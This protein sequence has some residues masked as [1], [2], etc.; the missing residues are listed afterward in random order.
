MKKTS[1]ASRAERKRAPG[2]T[3][4]KSLPRKTPRVRKPVG[5][6]LEQWQ[7]ALRRE[8]G[9]E[10]KFSA[11][12]IGDEEIFS[13]FIITNPETG[14]S[15]RAAI[16]GAQPG[17]NYCSCPD[18]SVN[19]LGTCKHLE[20]LLGKLE[21]KRGGKKA[22]REGHRTPYPEVYLRYGA[23]RQVVFNPGSESSIRLW[24]LASEYFD[25]P[26][27]DSSAHGVLRS[28]AYC[29][30]DKFLKTAKRLAPDLRVYDDALAFIAQARDDES[31][32]KLLRGEFPKGEDS[33][34]FKKLLNVSLYPYQRAGA[35]FA[36][37]A[38]RCLLADDM[39]LGKTIQ[40]IA[41][42][43]MLARTCGVE[44]VLVICPTSLKHQ[45]K[46]E[47]DR[48]CSRSTQVVEGLIAARA[49]CYR[50]DSFFKVTNYDVIH[51][52]LDLIH[53]WEPDLI[54]L[55]E[56][57]R[58]KNWKTRTAQSVKR[59]ESQY[60]I[61]LT[62]TPL[63][64]R[65]EELHSIVEFVDRFRLGPSFRFLSEHQQVDEGGRVIGY[66]DLSKISKTLDT[67][68]LRRGKGEVL[69]EL[70]ERLDKR[71]FVPMTEQQMNH[72]DE[73]S[74]IVAKLAAKWRRH[75]FLT[76]SEQR[77]LMISLQYMRMSCNSTYLIDHETDFGVKVK[78]LMNHLDDA[79]ED[80]EAKAV[81]F[82]QWTRT[83]ELIVG[84]FNARNGQRGFDHVFFHGGVPS[85]K[86][87]DLVQRFKNDPKCRVFLSTDAGGVGLNLQNASVVINMDQPW[88]P[89][90][91]EQR[92]GRVHR[93]GQRR[94][95]QVV[96]FVSKGTIEESMLG[97]LSFKKSVFAGVLDGGQDEVFLGGSRL[98]RFM[99]TV[100]KV[101][102]D[103]P[104]LMPATDSETVS[105]ERAQP[106]GAEAV[107]GLEGIRS[108]TRAERQGASAT[109]LTEGKALAP[110]SPQEALGSLVS[111]GIA[112]LGKLSEALSKQDTDRQRSAGA[113]RA[114]SAED[115]T[116]V[117]E[118]DP[119]T[120][121]AC[122][123]IPMP[124]PETLQ[125]FADML[126]G[127]TKK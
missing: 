67:I 5:M 121:K 27:D 81:V 114:A 107:G 80:P 95:V 4:K 60:A 87:K 63:E 29:C 86:R 33:P 45:W 25:L 7:Q 15:Y 74:A 50:S 21:R 20:W 17:D 41:A 65:I 90:I 110:A 62:G 118:T 97:L 30:F 103:E 52:D 91:L 77:R 73:H 61:V 48:F 42:A 76:E 102:S 93:L 43:E 24:N 126:G 36:A 119:E 2:A 105:R 109:P 57:Q 6:S 18:F 99:E 94:P 34:A 125:K 75:G 40:A 37:R 69:N 82:S 12:N 78:E 10:Q 124:E 66:T 35:L 115:A 19:T 98:K 31:R 16:R 123:R 111:A 54:I 84:E 39:G 116:P 89:A 8:F 13:E 49:Q 117:I 108:D 58:I 53:G 56:A 88:N 47:A 26:T 120:G 101:T 23:E 106:E 100:E 70:P 127:F 96:D 92:I 85:K 51:R 55:D 79:F 122:L 71:F 83:H 1:S 22:F 59:L 38:G 9:R 28:N 72:H 44:R 11:R 104:S 14:R 68:L 113:S 112:F 64:N 32:K 46:Q 3:K